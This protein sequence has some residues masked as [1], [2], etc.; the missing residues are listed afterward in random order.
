MQFTKMHGIGNDFVVIECLKH[1]YSEEELP[2]LSRTLCDRR[3]GVGGDGLILVLPSKQGHVMMRMFNPDGSEAEMCGNGIRCFA[4]YIYDRQIVPETSINVETMAGLKPLKLTLK[5]GK[6]SE[7]CVDMGCPELTPELIPVKTTDAGPVIGLQL[8]VAGRR[9]DVTC[10]SMGNPH[11]VAFA[12]DV[13]SVPLEKLGPL[14][15]THKIFPKKTN[16]HFVQ[17]ISPN[18]IKMRTW[19]RGAGITLACGTGAC[20]CA[21]AS[22]LNK[23][24]GR[25]VLIHLPGGDLQVEWT[26]GNRVLMTGPAEEVF[27]GELTL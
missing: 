24:T 23:L 13:D 5:S 3:F 25:S 7:V 2:E 20:S 4:K 15:E 17:V 19:E 6:V 8:K 1:T 21:V 27:T 12:D 11:A 26:G 22:H 16:V 10:V 14:I 18:E 9:V